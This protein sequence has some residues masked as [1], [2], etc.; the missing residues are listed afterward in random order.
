MPYCLS[1]GRLRPT[2]GGMCEQC[3]IDLGI[4]RKTEAQYDHARI[5]RDI[6]K[7]KCRGREN[8]GEA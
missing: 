3:R 7:A 4:R 8:N 6:A 2:N 5:M 1:C